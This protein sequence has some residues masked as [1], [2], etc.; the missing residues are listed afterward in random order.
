MKYRGLFKLLTRKATDEGYSLNYWA[1]AGQWT[2]KEGFEL[3]KTKHGRWQ[4][5]SSASIRAS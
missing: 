2:L 3:W 4:R 5:E 1:P